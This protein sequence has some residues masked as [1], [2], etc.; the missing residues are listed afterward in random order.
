MKYL[1][2]LRFFQGETTLGATSR[3]MQWT[4]AVYFV[5]VAGVFCRQITAFPKVDMN[6]DNLRW[7]VLA[8]SF[9][10]GLVV[11]P[12]VMRFLNGKRRTP[13]FE[14]ILSAFGVGFLID[15]SSKVLYE[16]ILGPL[17]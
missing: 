14:H 10:L 6:L 16:A 13:G 5:L 12:P 7:G 3:R 17:A 15:F 4:L 11:L 8:A 9:I 1:L 2:D